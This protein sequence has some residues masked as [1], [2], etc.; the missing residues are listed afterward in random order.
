MQTRQLAIIVTSLTLATTASLRAD[1]K[2]H[3]RNQ[4]RLKGRCRIVIMF[5]GQARAKAS[6]AR[7][8]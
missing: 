7:L 5:G 4:V 3:G 1:V 6:G 2:T 8:R